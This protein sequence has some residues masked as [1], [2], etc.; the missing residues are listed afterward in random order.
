MSTTILSVLPILLAITLVITTVGFRRMV[1]FLNIGYAFSIA[2]VAIASVG[3]LWK[4]ASFLVVLQGAAVAF[5]GLRLGIFVV[6]RELSA[7]YEKERARIDAEYNGIRLPAKF[8]IWV[9]VSVLY[10]MMVSPILFGLENSPKTFL[11]GSAAQWIGFMAMSGGLILE[12]I[13][14]RQKSAF[15]AKNPNTFC[16]T[17]L[18]RWV[19]CP[20]YLGEIT[21][22]VG[23]WVMGIAFYRTAF[24]WVISLMG[25]LCIVFIMF[26]STRRLERTQ[27]K[28]YGALPE[29][30][31]YTRTVPVL[32]P[33]V[34]LYSLQKAR[35]LGG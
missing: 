34:P 18:Y 14:D 27:V 21:F 24:E 2:A 8:V 6:K 1:Y 3:L 32:L 33:F 22:W 15:K 9:T 23:N 16:N 30:Q 19:R 13:A 7:N 25:M 11:S 31:Q 4:N 10:L 28:R 12:G 35:I 17:G 20:N 29:Y 5:W 26:G